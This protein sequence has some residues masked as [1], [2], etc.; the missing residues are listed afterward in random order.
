MQLFSGFVLRQSRMYQS[1]CGTA[2]RKDYVHKCILIKLHNSC[3]K[4]YLWTRFFVAAVPQLLLYMRLCRMKTHLCGSA[5]KQNRK[6]M[7]FDTTL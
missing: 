6:K 5:A 7:H 2:A 3:I 1:S 4:V